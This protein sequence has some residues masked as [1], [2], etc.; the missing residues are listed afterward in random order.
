MSTRSL[1]PGL[2]GNGSGLHVVV[3]S[4]SFLLVSV[5]GFWLCNYG[6][7]KNGCS[8]CC[9]ELHLRIHD[10]VL[11]RHEFYEKVAHDHAVVAYDLIRTQ[12]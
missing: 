2:G 10:T 7:F 11:V 8:M 5:F 1:S 9:S 4:S 6:L 12:T 3:G